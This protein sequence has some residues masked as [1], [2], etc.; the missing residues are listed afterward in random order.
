MLFLKSEYRKVSDSKSWLGEP[1]SDK[2]E[3]EENLFVHTFKFVQFSSELLC[4][5]FSC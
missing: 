3:I 4:V 2:L 1:D 5:S